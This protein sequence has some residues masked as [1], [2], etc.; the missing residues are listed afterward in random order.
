MTDQ[1]WSPFVH[2]SDEHPFPHTDMET[3]LGREHLP[4][5]ESEFLSQKHN[6]PLQPG[7]RVLPSELDDLL[8]P[9]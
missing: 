7:S 4:I 8:R 6:R 5:D 9:K 2:K 1:H 3:P